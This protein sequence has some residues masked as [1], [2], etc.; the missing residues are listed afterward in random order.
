[1]AS[2]VKTVDFPYWIM[3]RF[4]SSLWE[5]CSSAYSFSLSLGWVI[6]ADDENL[7]GLKPPLKSVL[8]HAVLSTKSMLKP[9]WPSSQ[10]AAAQ[11]M[12]SLNQVHYTQSDSWGYFAQKTSSHLWFS[13]LCIFPPLIFFLHFTRRTRQMITCGVA[14]E[15]ESECISVIRFR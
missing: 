4:F 6:S 8:I 1:M 15:D 2:W 14:G 12:L 11:S 13:F 5:V 3:G 9:V 10:Q 7:R